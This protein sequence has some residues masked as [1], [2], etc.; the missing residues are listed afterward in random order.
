MWKM[1]FPPGKDI[2]NLKA[3]KNHIIRKQMK[4]IWELIADLLELF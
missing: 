3:K 1:N 4:A 2:R